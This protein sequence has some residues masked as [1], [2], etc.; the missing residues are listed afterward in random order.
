MA[1]EITVSPSEIADETGETEA[2]VSFEAHQAEVLVNAE[3]V[4]SA[5]TGST[6]Q[7]R[8]DITGTLMAIAFVADDG[9]GPLSSITQESAQISYQPDNE[10][11][12]TYWRRAIQMDPTGRLDTIEEDD[13][14]FWSVTLTG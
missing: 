3:L 1:S 4:P 14:D 12:L 7:E 13:G 5:G 6:V 10:D 2:D 8:L 11:A 9:H